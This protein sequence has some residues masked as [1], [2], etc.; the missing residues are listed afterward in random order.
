M[1]ETD[2]P[3][4]DIDSLLADTPEPEPISPLIDSEEPQSEIHSV[5]DIPDPEPIDDLLEK[6]EQPQD[7]RSI[8]DMPEPPQWADPLIETDDDDLDLYEE[9]KLEKQRSNRAKGWNYL[10]L[11]L[12]T[13]TGLFLFMFRDTISTG[14][15]ASPSSSY[16][17]AV[18]PFRL[19]NDIEI[20][21]VRTAWAGNALIV[22]GNIRNIADG[23]K[24]LPELVF[25]IYDHNQKELQR[26]AIILPVGTLPA[27]G[28]VHFENKILADKGRAGRFEVSIPA[29]E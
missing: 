3:S 1:S 17:S 14:L 19:S 2:S 28:N 6:E 15:N 26:Q 16:I 9:L 13:L 12:F 18:T 4:E 7:S 25:V 20:E 24:P 5:F 21:D 10:L 27:G 8:H 29:K 11:S 23:K 22:T